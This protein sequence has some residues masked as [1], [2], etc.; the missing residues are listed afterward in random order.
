MSKN[1]IIYEGSKTENDL[2]ELLRHIASQIDNGM[3][4]GH[5]PGWEI[6]EDE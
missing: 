5:Y 1:V 3:T 6:V 4:S 2:A